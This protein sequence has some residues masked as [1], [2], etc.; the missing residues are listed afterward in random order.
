MVSTLSEILRMISSTRKHALSF[1]IILAL[2]SGLLPL[3]AYAQ[4]GDSLRSGVVDPLDSQSANIAEGIWGSC[5]WDISADRILTI[6]SGDGENTGNVSPWSKYAELVNSIVFESGV[7]APSSCAYLFKD[8]SANSINLSGLN[9][10]NVT[11]MSY[12]F[13]GCSFL[14]TVDLSKIDTSMVTKMSYMFENCLKIKVF[15][16]SHF[17]TS[18]VTDMGYMFSGCSSVFLESIDFSTFDTSKV[19]NMSGMFSDCK[20]IKTLYLSS[21]ST[22]N[23]TD[24]SNMF[25]NCSSLASLDLQRF[26]TSKV[27]NMSRMFSGCSNLISLDLTKFNTSNVRDMSRMFENC[28]LLVSLDL[29]AFDTSSVSNICG[30]FS[31]C[32]YLSSLDL[33]SI[34]TSNVTNMGS[35]FD[36]CSNL[37][38]LNLSNFDTSKVSIMQCMFRDCAALTSLDLSSFDT[39]N[40]TYMAY[41]F[42]GCSSLASLDLSD[43]DT[44]KVT[45]MN[46]IFQGCGSLTWLNLSSFDTSRISEMNYVFT[47]CKSLTSLDLS[48]FCTSKV[49]EMYD[50][51]SGCSSIASLDLSSFD[52]SNVLSFAN[53]F[54]GCSSLASLDL[55]SF[56]IRFNASANLMFYGCPLTDLTLGSK[57]EGRS[58]TY[59]WTPTGDQYSGKWVSSNARAKG[60]FTSS[61]LMGEWEPDVMAGNW[62][63]Q[64]FQQ[65][66]LASGKWGSCS[67]EVSQ[68]GTLTVHAGIGANT[69]RGVSPWDSCRDQIKTIVFEEGVIAPASCTSLFSTLLAVESIDLSGFDTS[70]VKD[71]SWMFSDCKSLTSL[72]LSMFNTSNVTDMSSMFFACDALESLQLSKFNT[73]RVTKMNSMFSCCSSLTSLDLSSFYTSDYTYMSAMLNKCPLVSIAFGPQWHSCSDLGLWKPTGSDYSGK[74]VSQDAE[75][76]KSLNNSEL[77]NNWSP[78]TMAGTWTAQVRCFWSLDSDGTLAITPAR[79]NQGELIRQN[80]FYDNYGEANSL[81]QQVR[82]I[83]F[84]GSVMMSEESSGVFKDFKNLQ[85]IDM[86]S[87]ATMQVFDGALVGLFEGC[88]SLQD[89]SGL[90]NWDVSRATSMNHLFCGC[91]SLNDLLV[92]ANWD[93]LNVQSMDR[94]F[95]GCPIIK[96]GFGSEWKFP[97]GCHPELEGYVPNGYLRWTSSDA[98]VKGPLTTNELVNSWNPATMAGTWIAEEYIP[99]WQPTY[100][101]TSSIAQASVA[102]ADATYTG[103][104]QTP[105]PVVKLADR[106]LQP[107]VDYIVSYSN[108][109][110]AGTATVFISGYG[111]YSGSISTTFA[112]SKANLTKVKIS[113][114]K[115]CAYTGKTLRPAP[116]VK[117][118]SFTLKPGRDFIMSYRNNKNVG[119]AMMTFKGTGNFA[120][121][122]VC[123]FRIVKAKQPMAAAGKTAT[124]KWSKV[125]KSSQTVS[126][127]KAF[128]IKKAKG[129]VTFKKVSGSKKITVASSGKV[130]VKKGLQRGTYKIKVKVTAKGNGSYK[131]GS[132][133]LTLKVRVK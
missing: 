96:I 95:G 99:P 61:E 101:Q 44:S 25:S 49:T 119:K 113:G 62:K 83:V 36:G 40:V 64:P 50:M 105:K 42:S 90:A 114:L 43:F 51:F 133:V 104:P 108:N 122:K 73:S 1:F 29:L 63:A 27:T 3:P 5:S 9:T 28:K 97:S 106:T 94:I 115:D 60:P 53:M 12:M 11:D 102:I 109:M 124:V 19:E 13:S 85:S 8:L 17:D 84:H 132:K 78:A 111:P 54:N 91:S 129:N 131:A 30:M 81:A 80:D 46:N 14:T 41:M 37:T 4:S 26:D 79:G 126:K 123:S 47:G 86:A 10:S 92:L 98:K 32:P 59:L 70:R 93:T 24:M 125:K 35:L 31:G 48:S 57:W 116:V 65:E 55:S 7:I 120:G 74:W 103:F 128:S 67:W 75:V 69:V 23:V 20:Y 22:L 110:N 21:F 6:H 82:R 100:P 16:L 52:T 2:V 112:I 66:S 68:N 130:T 15:D 71:M 118:G 127:A 33:S 89:I 56:T 107:G 77:I 38:S 18:N 45:T 39:S 58:N 72:D 34:N 121:S 88:T 87:G 76:K 117:L